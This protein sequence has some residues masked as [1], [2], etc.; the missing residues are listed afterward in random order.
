MSL[1]H[2]MN[3]ACILLINKKARSLSVLASL[4]GRLLDHVE[5]KNSWQMIEAP[6]VLTVI[7]NLCISR[8]CLSDYAMEVVASYLLGE[9]IH[10]ALE[11]ST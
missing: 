8:K 2:E 9:Y 6:R 7:K 11:Y 1:F 4:C 5:R 3:Y 10:I